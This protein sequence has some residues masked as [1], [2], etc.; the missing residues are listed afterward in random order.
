MKTWRRPPLRRLSTQWLFSTA[1]IEAFDAANN[2]AVGTGF[3]ISHGH[4]TGKPTH[5]VTNK[6]VVESS[7]HV[8]LGVN[9]MVSGIDF[10][11]DGVLETSTVSVAVDESMW[12]GHDDPSVDLCCID[13]QV[14]IEQSDGLLERLFAIPIN[15]SLFASDKELE[16]W[17]AM[18][19]IA[20]I[21]YPNGLWD[22][23]HNLPVL[24]NGM[25]ASLA[26]IDYNTKREVLLDIAVF[27]G[28]SGSPVML[29]DYNY[30]ASTT[31]LLGILYA[32]P[33]ITTE[34]QILISRIPT[35][36]KPTAYL[37]T[38]MNLGFAVRATELLTLLEK[39]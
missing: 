26:S 30:F 29:F 15:S 11:S 22:E 20:M 23:A 9:L 14:L 32:G 21:G 37:N 33:T 18:L 38:M 12:C 19:G 31:R 10:H 25:T 13:L 17:D 16:E 39:S 35:Q 2:I 5:L 8:C 28:S 1:R 24:R 6:H 27:P 36:D 3:F 4:E 34:G 7:H